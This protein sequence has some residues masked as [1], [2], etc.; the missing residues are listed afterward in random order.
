MTVSEPVDIPKYV[1]AR[2]R[3]IREGRNLTQAALGEAVAAYGAGPWPR[4]TV[5]LLEQGRRAFS[6]ADVYALA[7]ALGVEVAALFPASTG[8][9]V[10][11]LEDARALA[12][13][14]AVLRI[15]EG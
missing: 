13:G 5:F 11:D 3:M 4:Q 7:A 6:A 12:V 15:V 10:K 14:R 8:E 1:G 9:A 2:V